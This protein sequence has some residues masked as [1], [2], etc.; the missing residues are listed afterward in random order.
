MVNVSIRC[1][2]LRRLEGVV[3]FE[4]PSRDLSRNKKTLMKNLQQHLTLKRR[5]E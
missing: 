3:A 1:D 5:K 4:F 2:D